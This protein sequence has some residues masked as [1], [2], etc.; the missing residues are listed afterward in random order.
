MCAIA[1]N[2]WRRIAA[3]S[4]AGLA[5]WLASAPS[6]RAEVTVTINFDFVETRVSPRQEVYRSHITSSFKLSPGKG[7]DFSS[8]RGIKAQAKLGES[9]TGVD[10]SGQSSTTSY[11]IIGGAVVI[12]N[13]NQ[14]YYSVLRITTDGRGTCSAAIKYFRNPGH[15]YFEAI[16]VNGTESLLASNFR[17][18]NTTC[19]IAE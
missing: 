1:L 17:A 6:A 12:T 15:Q 16:T 13:H 7:V 11:Q 4:I 8:S 10:E 14:G 5:A 3:A 19:S 2:G 9:M 18:E